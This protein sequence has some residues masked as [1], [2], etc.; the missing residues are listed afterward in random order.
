M[1]NSGSVEIDRPIDDV[2]RLTNDHMP[3]WSKTVVEDQVVEEK[4]DGVGTTFR[5]ITEDHGKRMEF[6]GVV[7]KYDPPKVSA[8]RMTNNMLEIESE[9]SFEDL[10]GRTRVT[11]IANVKGKGFYR[12]MMFVVGL[13]MKK[14][15]CKASENELLSLKRFCE[16]PAEVKA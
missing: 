11:Q 2:F 5:M 12:L 4:L 9:F 1:Q 10:S 16:E 14:A 6:D 3:E 15:G 13:F 7:T 8:A